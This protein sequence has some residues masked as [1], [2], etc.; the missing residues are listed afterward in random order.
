MKNKLFPTLIVD[1]FLEDPFSTIEYAKT[2]EFNYPEPTI[3]P[4]TRTKCLSLLNNDLYLKT[5]NNIL[6]CYLQGVPFNYTAECYFQKID[7]NYQEG[8]IHRD[9]SILTSIIYLSQDATSESGTSLYKAKKEWYRPGYNDEK[10]FMFNRAIKDPKFEVSEEEKKLINNSNSLFEET[11]N[12]KNMFNRLISFE[13][14]IWHRANS[15]KNENP[16]LTLIIFFLEIFVGK[17]QY[18]LLF[19]R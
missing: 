1:D 2:L 3:Y 11:I 8:W 12:I 13:G 5:C 4:G 9:K 6:K 19:H 10:I 15:L 7:R 14:G 16:R 17:N 18:P